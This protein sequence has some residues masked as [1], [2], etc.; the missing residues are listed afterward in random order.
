MVDSAAR[1]QRRAAQ[2]HLPRATQIGVLTVVSRM[3]A[4]VLSMVDPAA[5]PAVDP[6]CGCAKE[7]LVPLLAWFRGAMRELPPVEDAEDLDLV[8]VLMSF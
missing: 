6:G 7:A 2:T 4:V 3:Q 1:M 8:R 5:L